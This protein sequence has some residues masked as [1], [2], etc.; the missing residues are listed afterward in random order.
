MSYTQTSEEYKLLHEKKKKTQKTL[1]VLPCV[2]GSR[3]G[4]Q[5]PRVG[6]MGSGLVDLHTKDIVSV[7][8]L[9][10]LGIS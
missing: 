2:E 8:C 4:K 5:W 10:S 9:L 3:G 7:S 6:S 1:L